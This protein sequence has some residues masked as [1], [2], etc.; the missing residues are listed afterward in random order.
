MWALI[1]EKFVND[2]PAIL[3]RYNVWPVQAVPP[4]PNQYESWR[5]KTGAALLGM[6]LWNMRELM[7]GYVFSLLVLATPIR[8]HR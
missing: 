1:G 3:P 8:A 4:L 2:G 6:P 7:A 5:R